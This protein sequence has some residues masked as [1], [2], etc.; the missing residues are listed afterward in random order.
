MLARETTLA[1]A[2]RLGITQYAVVTGNA[3]QDAKM[4]QSLVAKVPLK[5][6]QAFS[7]LATCATGTKSL[8]GDYLVDPNNGS[9]TRVYFSAT[10]QVT[11]D[12]YN[13]CI[14]TNVQ[15]KSKVSFGTWT[16]LKTCVRDVDSSCTTR[17]VTM[18]TNWSGVYGSI[19]N[20]VPGSI[21]A[22]IS[23]RPC[24][25]CGRPYTRRTFT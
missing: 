5:R 17:N 15:D 25:L 1:E 14:V 6:N 3:K 13:Q 16:W 2:R 21:Y 23:D 22:H 9:S 11:Y 18:T 20:S 7:T 4:E 8:G 24:A 12:Q 10:Y 19:Y